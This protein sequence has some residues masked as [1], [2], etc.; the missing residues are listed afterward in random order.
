ME[1]G[2]IILLLALVL[3]G[4]GCVLSVL[5]LI[6]PN[7]RY[8]S[9]IGYC[10]YGILLAL[11]SAY[12]LLTY[13][14]LNLDF[15]VHYVWE[16]SSTSLDWPLRFAGVWAGQE[17]S[18]LLW[19]W[20]I[21]ISFGIAELYRYFRMEGRTKK[22]RTFWDWTRTLMLFS[23][24]VFLFLMVLKDP[25]TA[26][27]TFEVETSE[28]TFMVDPDASPDGRGLNP[29]LRNPWMIIHPPILF[30]GYA[31]INLPFAAGLAYSITGYKKWTKTSLIWSRLA[32]LSLTLGIGIGAVWAYIALGWGGYWAWDPVEVG[33]LLPWFALTAFLH[34]QVENIRA[35]RYPF[36]NP[37]LGMASFLLVIFATFITRS[38]AWESV[39]AW[40]ENEVGLVLLALMIGVLIFGFIVIFLSFLK[41]DSDDFLSGNRDQLLMFSTVSLLMLTTLI[42]LAALLRTMSSPDPQLFEALLSPLALILLLLLST[43]LAWRYIGW[44]N[45]L[46]IFAWLGII[47]IGISFIIDLYILPEETEKLLGSITGHH[48]FGFII[49]FASIAVALCF[50]KVFHTLRRG[51][52]RN[53]LRNSSPHIIHLGVVFILIG[54]GLSQTFDR[55]ETIQLDLGESVTA[56]DH[57]IT[58]EDFNEETGPDED[59]IDITI[60]V[61]GADTVNPQWVYYKDTDQWVSKIAISSSLVGDL[62]VVAEDI[63]PDSDGEIDTIILTIRSIPGMSLLWLG[64]IL[65]S[66][67]IIIRTVTWKTKKD[68][69]DLEGADE[70]EGMGPPFQRPS[71]RSADEIRSR[72][73]RPK[74]PGRVDDKKYEDL[75]EKELDEIEDD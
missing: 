14:F 66:I 22:A 73:A 57:E 28:G 40:E 62:Y 19:A 13:Y 20:L 23:L 64:M 65:L 34:T 37:F 70:K 60:E 72:R 53:R 24:L 17:G 41:R 26:T 27:H 15:S 1:P 38:G 54:Y 55:E 42:C 9:F 59:V 7:D 58:F 2:S 10:I 8:R 48:I 71:T 56:I 74:Y 16:H 43:C 32:W 49:P 11:T 44:E 68:T 3:G 33:S 63:D 50:L 47:G 46:Y 61:D 35:K 18:L 67:G 39:H 36:L 6:S 4:A 25:F 31:F 69:Q 21:A 12:L 29:Q 51:N 45:S 5:N 52:L 75:L 30:I